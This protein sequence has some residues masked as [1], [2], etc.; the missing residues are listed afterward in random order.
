MKNRNLLS[1][2]FGRMIYIAYEHPV[3]SDLY[4]S[5]GKILLAVG[6]DLDKEGVV[7]GIQECW[8]EYNTDELENEEIVHMLEHFNVSF[9]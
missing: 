6:S 3:N 7:S 8:H 4:E 5:L 2:E 9:L 1:Y